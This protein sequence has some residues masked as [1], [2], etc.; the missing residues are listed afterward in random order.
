MTPRTST[1]VLTAARRG[2]ARR[3]RAAVGRL[4]G[5][6]HAAADARAHARGWSVTPAP[7]RF[8]LAGRVYRDP[9]FAARQM[10]VGTTTHQE[11]KV[12]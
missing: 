4:A 1:S 2:T 10:T 8:G 3:V 5:R 6:A 9:R 7:G 11:R 12:A